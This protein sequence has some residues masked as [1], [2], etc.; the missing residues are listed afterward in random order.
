[1]KKNIDFAGNQDQGARA[2]QEDDSV[3]DFPSGTR[4]ENPVEV[5]SLLAVL[6]DGMGGHVGGAAASRTACDAF[7][8]AYRNNRGNIAGR[9]EQSLYAADRA[10]AAYVARH[11]DLSG[12][13]CTLVGVLYDKGKINWISVGDSLLYLYRDGKIR[14]LNEDH[15]MAPQIDA[16][17]ERGQIS[18]EEARN[19]QDRNV[20]ISV[21]RGR[22][23]SP[24]DPIDKGAAPIKI[25]AGDWVLVASDGLQSLTDEEIA[26]HTKRNRS[27]TAEELVE[28]L[29]REVRNKNSPHQDNTTIIAI[30]GYKQ[31]TLPGKASGGAKYLLIALC[32][33]GAAY[34]L[35]HWKDDVQTRL[36]NVLV[37]IRWQDPKHNHD[38]PIKP[39]AI[40]IDDI[41]SRI[42]CKA[43]PHEIGTIQP[44]DGQWSPN[45]QVAESNGCS[46]QGV[47][48]IIPDT[49]PPSNKTEPDMGNAGGAVS[50]KTGGVIVPTSDHVSTTNP[51]MQG[52]DGPV[53][54]GAGVTP[55]GEVAPEDVSNQPALGEQEQKTGSDGG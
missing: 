41:I 31:G 14:R 35:F 34:G 28:V 54:D 11:P 10:I 20:L 52:T 29:L 13:G 39:D 25:K 23:L 27:G 38:G 50:D 36:D 40:S 3:F 17:A 12:M 55:A 9:L 1:M 49:A 2:Y 22:N 21:V 7:A 33:A 37:G 18:W 44:V 26:A 16:A 45:E 15:S 43:Q 53:L 24:K 5:D 32:L 19:H 51:G 6:A 30:K 47:L 46:G 4:R 48:H 8:L 42:D